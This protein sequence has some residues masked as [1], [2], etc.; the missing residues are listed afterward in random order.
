MKLFVVFLLLFPLASSGWA[1]EKDTKKLYYTK[2]EVKKLK[3]FDQ[4]YKVFKGKKRITT[5]QN[6]SPMRKKKEVKPREKWTLPGGVQRSGDTGD[7]YVP[8]PVVDNN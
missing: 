8:V 3:I 4:E 5:Y 1:K 6:S 2:E 7:S